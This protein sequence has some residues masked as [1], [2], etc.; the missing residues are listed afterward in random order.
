MDESIR[1]CYDE[2]LSKRGKGMREAVTKVINAA[3]KRLPGENTKNSLAVQVNHPMLKNATSHEQGKFNTGYYY[4]CIYE[5][6]KTKAGS[7][8]DLEEA[9]KKQRVRTTGSGEFEDL[10]FHFPMGKAGQE[11]KTTDFKSTSGDA[12]ISN[13]LI[14]E[15]KQFVDEAI[16]NEGL[17]A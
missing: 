4:R 3:F 16:P 17:P 14:K 1:A 13:E 9:V 10:V 15:F 7:R 12:P 5:E 11:T 8:A 2:A 6:A